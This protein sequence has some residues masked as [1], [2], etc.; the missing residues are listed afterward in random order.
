MY[1]KIFKTPV[2]TELLYG[3]LADLCVFENEVYVFDTASFK[4]GYFNNSIP[5]FI[6]ELRKYYHAKYYMYL[7]RHLSYTNFM[8]ILRHICK[9]NDIT[10][11]KEIHYDRSKYEIVY[12]IRGVEPP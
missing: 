1:Q 11:T 2:P 10:Y 6:V 8:T 7:D 9:A 3:L 5:I 4:K 12:R